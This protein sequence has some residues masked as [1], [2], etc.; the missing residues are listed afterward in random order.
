[1]IRRK[2]QNV[3]PIVIAAMMATLAAI[4][5]LFVVAAGT[6]TAASGG[7]GIPTEEPTVSGQKAK[8]LKDGRAIPPKSAPRVVKDVIAAANKIRNKPYIY[9]GGHGSFED[10]GYDCSGAVSYALHG[11]GLLSSPMPSGSFMK[12]G[13]KGAGEWIS[14]YSHGGHMYMTVAGLRWDTSGNTDGTDG[15]SWHKQKRS[16]KGFTVT[17]PKG[18]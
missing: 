4:A 10:K 1:M 16:P 9:G 2:L 17:H 14:I 5:L 13:D 3:D 11:G 7:V 8:L 18:L 15:P 12:W 6:A